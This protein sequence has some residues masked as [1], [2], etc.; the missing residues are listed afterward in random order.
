VDQSTDVWIADGILLDA[1]QRSTT[2]VTFSGSGLH[3]PRTLRVIDNATVASGWQVSAD[4]RNRAVSALNSVAAARTERIFWAIQL[5]IM[6]AIGACL[7]VASASRC[8]IQARRGPGSKAA[9]TIQ[10][11]YHRGARYAAH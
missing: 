3:T 1:A 8:I 10:K 11:D 6:L 4:Y 7:L 5:P 2:V 9:N